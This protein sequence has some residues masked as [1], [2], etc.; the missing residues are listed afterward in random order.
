MPQSPESKFEY[1][2]A[3][4]SLSVSTSSFNDTAV[5]PKHQISFSPQKEI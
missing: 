5:Q 4:S 1:P 2:C 3:T